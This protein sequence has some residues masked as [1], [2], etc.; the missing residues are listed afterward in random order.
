MG[1]RQMI[2]K[3][4]ACV[5]VDPSKAVYLIGLSVKGRMA[6]KTLGGVEG[7]ATSSSGAALPGCTGAASWKV[8]S[9]KPNPQPPYPARLSSLFQRTSLA[10]PSPSL[11]LGLSPSIPNTNTHSLFRTFLASSA[12]TPAPPSPIPSSSLPCSTRGKEKD[13]SGRSMG[14][15]G[16]R[17]VGVVGSSFASWQAASKQLA[18]L[19]RLAIGRQAGQHAHPTQAHHRGADLPFLLPLPP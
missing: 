17:D 10:S 18:D 7:G 4:E 8:P 11:S 6:G 14:C 1:D 9:R 15:L 12:F 19:S 3:S 16:A 2:D 5:R 13:S